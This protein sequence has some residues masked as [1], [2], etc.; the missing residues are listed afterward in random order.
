MK[1]L[2]Q[3]QK[4]SAIL[5]NEWLNEIANADKEI[6]ENQCSAKSLIAKN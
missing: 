6:I 2:K 3:K 1:Y 4:A 5:N